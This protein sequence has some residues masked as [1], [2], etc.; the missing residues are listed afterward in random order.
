MAPT[1]DE[2]GGCSTEAVVPAALR[3][4]AHSMGIDMQRQLSLEAFYIQIQRFG[5]LDQVILIEHRLVFEEQIMHVPEFA[6]RCRSFCSFCSMPGMRMNT[7][8]GKM[9]VDKPQLLT[10]EFLKLFHDGVGC[11]TIWTFV[12][13]IF[14]EGNRCIGR[15]LYMITLTN[16]EFQIKRGLLHHVV[17]LDIHRVLP[18]RV[19]GMVYVSLIFYLAYHTYQLLGHPFAPPSSSHMELSGPGTLV[20]KSH[21]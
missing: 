12:I 15:S 7:G 3:V 6:L 16:W 17:F 1:I 5:I 2:E 21:L 20:M 9:T 19:M 8:E 14:H 4:L 18:P 13:S 11:S 10:E